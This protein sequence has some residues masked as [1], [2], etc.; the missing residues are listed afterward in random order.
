MVIDIR[1]LNAELRYEGELH[2]TL[3]PDNGL[4]TVPLAQMA[5]GIE[6][7]GVYRLYEDDTL[8]VRGKVRF[9]LRG[10]CSRC[11]QPA[12]QWLEAEWDPVFVRGEPEE[13]EYSYERDTVDLGQSVKDAVLLGMPHVLLCKENCEGIA[14]GGEDG[15]AE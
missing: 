9:L 15:K 5:S 8:E 13:E 6:A 12:E 10:A 4:V 1:K 3:P 11:L 14:Y 2:F 7:N